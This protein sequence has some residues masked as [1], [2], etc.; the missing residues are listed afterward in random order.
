MAKQIKCDRCPRID[1]LRTGC[2]GWKRI[3][4]KD[5]CP[6]C[7]DRFLDFMGGITI[8]AVEVKDESKTG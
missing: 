7:S 8:E 2:P 4:Q 1:E 6:E 5:L 3:G